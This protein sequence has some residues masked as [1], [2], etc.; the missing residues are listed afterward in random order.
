MMAEPSFSYWYKRMSLGVT[1]CYISLR[2]IIVF[3]FPLG[4]SLRFLGGGG[5]GGGG[6]VA[7]EKPEKRIT[8]EM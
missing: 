1:C 3:G 8:F 6:V 2:I 5:G 4:P 7:E